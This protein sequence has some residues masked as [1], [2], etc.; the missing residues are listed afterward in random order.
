MRDYL[1]LRLQGP[2]QAWGD[3]AVDGWR[4]SR[5][6]PSLSALAGMLGSA[7]GWTYQD[8]VL[9]NQLQDKLCYAV[10]EER[11]PRVV[12]D[13]HTADLDRIGREGW[14]RWGLERRGGANAAG[15]QLQ[16]KQYLADGSFIVALTL[17]A[18][19]PA[20][21]SDVETALTLPARPIFL[22]RKGCLPAAQILVGR[23]E[24]ERSYDAL[25][26][27]ASLGAGKEPWQGP[28]QPWC[29]YGKGDGPADA[30][31]QTVW[32]RRDFATDR[33][34]GSRTVSRRRMNLSQHREKP[35]QANAR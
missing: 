17:D 28:P 16:R 20:S 13:F 10:L 18:G 2:L 8:A 19:A 35:E 32:D 33:F 9:T 27:W 12:Q 22:G 34:A 31:R 25:A 4:P 11:T 5:A 21:L 26:T 14:T 6:F 1:I 3:V 30:E 7:L 29:W 15:T 24:A 23:A